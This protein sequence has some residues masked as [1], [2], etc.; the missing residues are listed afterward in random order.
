[1]EQNK[2][3]EC[4][5]DYEIESVACRKLMKII[6]TSGSRVV[7]LVSNE[8]ILGGNSTRYLI[9]INVKII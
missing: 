2:R 1:M 3:F 7:L 4:Y 5:G 8:P 6:A 9:S